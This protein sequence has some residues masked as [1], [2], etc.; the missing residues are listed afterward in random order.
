MLGTL[1]D[2]FFRLSIFIDEFNSFMCSF[3]GEI[4]ALVLHTIRNFNYMKSFHVDELKV[5]WKT[6]LRS[7]IFF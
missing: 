7:L 4:Y 5:S 1:L 2:L 6:N 3:E